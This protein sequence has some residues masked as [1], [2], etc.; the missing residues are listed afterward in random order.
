MDADVPIGAEVQV[1]WGE[2]DGGS[3]KTT[4]QPHQQLAV[5]AVVSPVPYAITAR[6][7]YHGGWRTGLI[8]A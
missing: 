1:V 7:E 6:S 3:K 8:S 5:R 2:P 4:V